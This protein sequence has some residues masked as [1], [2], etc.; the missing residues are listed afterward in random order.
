MKGYNMLLYFAGSMIMNEPTEECVV[1]FWKNGKLRNLPVSSSN[2]R[3]L[4][5]AEL[6]RDSCTDKTRC[7]YE[8]SDDFFR[9]F[10]VSG[11]PLA[12]AYASIYVKRNEGSSQSQERVTEFYESYRWK[13]LSRT[14]F[15]DDHLGVELLFLTRMIDKY[16]MLDDE[17]C[18]LEMRK[19][20]KRYIDHHLLSWVPHWN[21]DIQEHANTLCYRGIGTLI[22]ASIEDLQGLFS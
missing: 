17:P 22:H 14:K 19:E 1:D 21:E 10:A 16:L 15:P 2:P 13:F 4:K 12:P 6:L 7:K 9:L 20:I 18:R 8:L 11:L 5:A 3:F